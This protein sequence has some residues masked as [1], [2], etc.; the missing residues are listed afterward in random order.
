M[1]EFNSIMKMWLNSLAIFDNCYFNISI[2]II[3]VLYSSVIFENINVYV[4]ELYNY[5]II[6]LIVLLLIIYIA[7][8]S[9]TISILLGISYIISIHYMSNSLLSSSHKL[10]K[11]QMGEIDPKLVNEI[12][13]DIDKS[14]NEGVDKTINVLKEGDV[15]TLCHNI[16]DT[17]DDMAAIDNP[18]KAINADMDKLSS[19]YEKV[20]KLKSVKNLEDFVKKVSGE[21]Q[22]DYSEFKPNEK[23]TNSN[24]N[25][26]IQQYA[27]TAKKNLHEGVKTIGDKYDEFTNQDIKSAAGSFVKIAETNPIIQQGLKSV[28]RFSNKSLTNTC[29][30]LYIPM[31]G[32]LSNS[33]EPVKLFST[34]YN[35]QGLDNEIMGQNI[36]YCP[37]GANI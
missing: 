35:A 17:L 9:P 30:K 28:D 14:I 33:C 27:A 21:I 34:E 13:N 11:F 18:E 10:E 22:Q 19:G 2:V 25:K 6:R 1:N 4:S 12:V 3:L 20:Q 26:L 29:E 7:P 5:S 16:C 36:N 23:F 37:V 8:K 31:N 15:R 24:S 32:Q